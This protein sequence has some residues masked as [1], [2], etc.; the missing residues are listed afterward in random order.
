[1]MGPEKSLAYLLA[2]R[3]YDVWMA[4]VRG[5]TYSRKHIKYDPDVD[6]KEFWDFSW[7]EIGIYDIPAM[8]D[9]IINVTGQEKMH[10]V[11]HS[12]GTTAFFVTG[13]EKPEYHERVRLM[14]A[15]APAAALKNIPSPIVRFVGDISGIYGVSALNLFIKHRGHL[16][17]LRLYHIYSVNMN[18]YPVMAS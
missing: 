6:K 1:M 7:H 3:G 10:Y 15:F 5:N 9:H 14:T 12:Q 8:M 2:D 11:G 16:C 18:Y 17:F 4:N 13:S